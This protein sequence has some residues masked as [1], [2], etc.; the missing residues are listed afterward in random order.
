MIPQGE[1]LNLFEY[2]EGELFWK[3]NRGRV[4]IGDHAGYDTE[5]G[6]RR[7]RID[8]KKY[9]VHVLV[10]IFHYGDIPEGFLVD[11]KNTIRSCN[12]IDNLRLATPSQNQHNRLKTTNSST[13]QYKGVSWHTEYSKWRA[14][15][16]CN[17]K[18][19]H[20][21]YFDSE[22]E[23]HEAYCELA[24]NIFGEFFN[25]GNNNATN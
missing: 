4:K 2:E 20:I 23:A 10:W 19:M 17:N 5:D 24:K 13:S 22:I 11:H 1:L 14:S 12:F 7:I 9:Y 3:V 16:E 21:G 25:N 8:G 18:M 6:Y 15:I